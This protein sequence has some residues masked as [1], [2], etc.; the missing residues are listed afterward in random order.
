MEVERIREVL[1][2]VN[3]SRLLS[4]QD[5]DQIQP[6]EPHSNDIQPWARGNLGS[7]V[8]EYDKTYPSKLKENLGLDLVIVKSKE[9][10]QEIRKVDIKKT[11]EIANKWISEAE[12]MIEVTKKDIVRSAKWYLAFK[13]L[14]ERYNANA[15][16]TSS[17]AFLTRQYKYGNKDS[18][19]GK[20]D[21][22]PCLAEMELAKDLIPCC[23]ENLVD[24]TITEMLGVYIYGRPGFVGDIIVPSE[25]K[26]Y[27]IFER[28]DSWI[29]EIDF[30]NNIIVFGHCYGPIN[31][32]GNDRVP[33]IIRSHAYYQKKKF[34]R[35]RE[36]WP[37]LVERFKREHITLVGIQVKWPI[38]ETVTIAK[39]DV[40][41]KKI[42]VFTGKTVDGNS[43][44]KEF[45]NRYCRTKI[46]VKV[47]DV[48]SLI[49]N[50]DPSFGIHRVVF[51][52]NYRQTVRD[53]AKLIGF[54]VVEEDKLS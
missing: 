7:P 50:L 31:P 6:V 33:Y 52:G 13:S 37:E 44:Y 5:F 22:M 14:M 28:R 47:N 8:T 48:G 18:M 21:A 41:N 29:D 24:D 1:E 25:E 46:A 39:T 16:T 43:F 15:I 2:I 3:R 32:H 12:D 19:Y 26:F 27:N 20:S 35:I 42:A 9:L 10:S 17:W 36:E 54:E 34:R 4:I 53:L 11:E 23:C 45:D 49:K 30:S 51:Y 38:D 40:Y